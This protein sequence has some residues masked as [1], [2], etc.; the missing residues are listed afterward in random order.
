VAAIWSFEKVIDY[1]KRGR[2]YGV[3]SL[4]APASSL[5]LKTSFFRVSRSYPQTP[6]HGS[7]NQATLVNAARSSRSATNIPHRPTG[8]VSTESREHLE[9]LVMKLCSRVEQLTALLAE[10]QM[11]RNSLHQHA[12]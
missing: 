12:D 3:S 7:L 5:S 1:F 11:E 2:R 10:Q 4:A 8:E 6:L 9:S